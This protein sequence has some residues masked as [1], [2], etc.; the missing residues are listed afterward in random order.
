M[1]QNRQ[2]WGSH[3]P[4]GWLLTTACSLQSTFWPKRAERVAEVELWWNQ[5]Q[6]SQ[7]Q[8]RTE[9]S[10]TKHETLFLMQDLVQGKASTF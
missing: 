9:E 1:S 8:A 4:T 7:T 5:V 6:I 10:Q 2:W 3:H